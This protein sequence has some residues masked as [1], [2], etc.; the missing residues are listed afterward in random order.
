MITAR[1][2]GQARVVARRALRYAD[3][4][5]PAIGRPPYVRAA[6]GLAWAKVDGRSVL[7]MP[8]D[9]ASFAAWL[10][11][12]D[13]DVH[14]VTLDHVPS[15]VRVFE[16][17]AGTKQLKLDLESIAAI[18][19]TRALLI[20]SGSHENRRRIV[21]LEG[22]RSRIVDCTALYE[23]LAARTDFAGSELNIEGAT[24][25]GDQL[26]LANRGNG[27]AKGELGPVDAVGALS[28]DALFAYLDGQSPAPALASVQ[29]FDL[30]EI[31][32]GRLGFTDLDTAPDGSLWF[33]ACA[34][35]SPNAYDDGQVVGSAVGHIDLANG[36]AVLAPL[37]A[38]DGT[39]SRDKPEGLAILRDESAYACIDADDPDAPSQLFTLS[40]ESIR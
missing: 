10:V 8:Q 34:E 2:A 16:K 13:G 37:L 6:S 18:D 15:G 33:L 3:G 22:E 32:G 35:R 19:D 39:P 12:P 11:P 23:S 31:E 40:L 21:V 4:G 29:A 38:E 28:L 5:D 26:L 20:G 25:M 9:D 36:T 24:R 17:R 1:R 27:A 30:G 7:V 14:A